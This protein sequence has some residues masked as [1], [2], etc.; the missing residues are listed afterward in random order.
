[1]LVG[2]SLSRSLFY[3]ILSPKSN[4]RIQLLE[5]WATK[6]TKK[7]DTMYMDKQLD[8]DQMQRIIQL[9]FPMSP[10]AS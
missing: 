2:G 6:I 7:L 4:L 8:S 1:M 3:F 9:R 5:Q 10:H